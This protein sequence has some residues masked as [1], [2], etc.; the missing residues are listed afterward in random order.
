MVTMTRDSQFNLRLNLAEQKKLKELATALG[1]SPSEVIRTL[2]AQA[3]AR[4]DTKV[5]KKQMRAANSMRKR[6][7]GG[8]L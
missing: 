3:H 7:L 5:L 6:L 8:P 4:M 2:V 1:M